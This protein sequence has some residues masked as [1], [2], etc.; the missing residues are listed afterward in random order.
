MYQALV[1]LPSSSDSDRGE[2]APRVRFDWRGFVR[3]LMNMF[4]HP[5][6]S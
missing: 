2:A 3:T 5:P 6:R 1:R 4:A